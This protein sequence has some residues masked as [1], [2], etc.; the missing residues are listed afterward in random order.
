MQNSEHTSNIYQVGKIKFIVTPVYES[1]Q[2]ESLFSVL[3]RLMKADS[4]QA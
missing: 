1:S 3:L 2:G 4:E